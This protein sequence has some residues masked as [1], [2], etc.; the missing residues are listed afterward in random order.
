MAIALSGG[1]TNF[2]STIEASPSANRTVTVPDTSFTVAGINAAQTFT[3]D[4][5]FN[6]PTVFSAGTASLPSI[7][8]TGDTNT[9]IFSPAADTIAFT[10]GGVES[11]RI[12]SSGNLGLGVT[13]SAWSGLSA[14]QLNTSGSISS[15]LSGNGTYVAQNWYY[16]GGDK[17]V[18]NAYALL[19][20]QNKS[21]GSHVWYRSTTSNASGAGAT[22]TL[23]QAMTLASTGQ[24]MLGTTSTD[25]AL[26]VDIQNVSASSNNV[27][28]QI[29]NVVSAEDT[30]LII[31]GNNGGQREYRIGVNT[32]ANTPDLTFSG[33]T[34]FQWYVGGTERARIDSS[35]NLLVGTTSGISGFKLNVG[36]A[37]T[38]NNSA[39]LRNDG[40]Q[41]LSFS[42]AA[43]GLTSKAISATTDGRVYILSNADTTTGQYMTS[44]GTS[45]NATS[46]E[47]LKENLTPITGAV[48]KISTL[49]AVVGNYISDENKTPTPFLIAQDVQAVLPEAVDAS[50]ENELGLSYTG[51]IPL[52]VAA[53]KEQQAIITAL[54][55]DVAALKGTA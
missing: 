52:L 32:I 45:W 50:N 25:S 20:E 27:L 46:D 7:T 23:T 51:I 55:A 18:G 12:D 17:F 39:I 16:N 37:T 24:L 1:S 54:Q 33:P 41:T 6:N 34:G 10:E 31:N 21:N 38:T 35:G 42:L 29:K 14:I 48:N 44:G 36:S 28:V 49:R 8:F 4:Q 22:A 43:A 5:T 11:M 30:G 26:S 40:T 15:G 53:I 13:P 19:Y 2:T 3:A 47:R 9:G